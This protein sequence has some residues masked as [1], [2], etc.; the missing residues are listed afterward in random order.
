MARQRIRREEN[1][2]DQQHQ[3]AHT[4]SKFPFKIEREEDVFPQKEQEQQRK[5]QKI[6]VYVLQ[7]ERKFRLALV[8]PLSF[9]YRASRRVQE[10]RAIV[11]LAVVIAGSA[12][13]QRSAENQQRRRKFPPTMMLI[14]QRRI[15]WREIRSPLIESPL[16]RS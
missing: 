12:K 4:H 11:G 1:D 9:A 7:N 2:V 10:K 5:I 3:R 6:P 15:K 8:V 16:E 13:G 14:N